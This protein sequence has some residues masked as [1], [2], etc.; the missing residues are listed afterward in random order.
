MRHQQQQAGSDH[1]DRLPTF[2]STLDPFQHSQMVGI[3]KNP[4]RN[5]KT[6][7]VFVLVTVIFILIP[8]KINIHFCN[9]ILII[10]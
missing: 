1:A 8:F 7:T 6:D 3:Q 4:L 2:F 5:L 9:Y 10:I